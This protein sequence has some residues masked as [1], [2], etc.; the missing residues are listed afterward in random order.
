V[1]DNA[2]LLTQPSIQIS[3]ATV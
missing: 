2:G 1:D 3:N